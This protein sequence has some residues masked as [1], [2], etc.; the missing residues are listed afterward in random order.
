MICDNC[1]HFERCKSILFKNENDIGYK[2]VCDYSDA[3]SCC[4]FKDR[5]NF[6]EIPFIAMIEQEIKDGKFNIRRTNRN[7]AM[8]VVY[9]DKKKWNK[10]L[11]DITSQYYKTDESEQRILQLKGN[12]NNG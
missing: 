7:G 4:H 9:I 6:I 11:I 1:I 5:N 2:S 10:P 8:A 3:E 12:D